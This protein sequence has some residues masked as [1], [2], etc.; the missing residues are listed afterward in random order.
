VVGA[1]G[2][3]LLTVRC[4]R[5]GRPARLLAALHARARKRLG[6]ETALESL[7]LSELAERLDSDPCREFAR[8][9]Q[10]AVFRD[11]ALTAT[12]LRRLKALLRV[13]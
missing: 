3:V 9:Y 2:V 11:R 5:P 13:I 8:I 4:R 12:E 7:G 6:R 1:L 10:G